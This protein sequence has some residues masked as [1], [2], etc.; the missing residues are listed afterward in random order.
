MGQARV[1]NERYGIEIRGYS[2]HAEV[3]GPEEILRFLEGQSG[4]V[5]VMDR[6][7]NVRVL[8]GSVIEIRSRLLHTRERQL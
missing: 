3:S 7:T 1:K 5:L 6:K 4:R 8:E 2:T